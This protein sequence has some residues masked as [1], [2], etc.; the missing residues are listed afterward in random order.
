MLV[1]LYFKTVKAVL[2]RGTVFYHGGASAPVGRT[3][4]L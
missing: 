2:H 3:S 4:A 1:T